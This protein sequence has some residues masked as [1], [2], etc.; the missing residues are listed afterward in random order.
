MADKLIPGRSK[1]V[2]APPNGDPAVGAFNPKPGA[3]IDI[4]V[5]MYT[6]RGQETAHLYQ[7]S[8]T[9][10][11]TP[12]CRRPLDT[13]VPASQIVRLRSGIC[14]TCAREAQKIFLKGGDAGKTP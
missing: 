10:K 2:Q 12:L 7:Q 11:R 8:S 1:R 14:A 4:K 13:M 6:P 9:G 5:F 3:D